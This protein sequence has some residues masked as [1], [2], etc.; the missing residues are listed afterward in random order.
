MHSHNT[1]LQK[2][3]SLLLGEN[4]SLAAVVVVVTVGTI[5]TSVSV[6]G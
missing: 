5:V 6:P 1:S 4:D 2:K 3:H